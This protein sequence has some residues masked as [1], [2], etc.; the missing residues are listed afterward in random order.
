[1]RRGHRGDHNV[2][3][4]RLRTLLDWRG[5]K[6]EASVSQFLTPNVEVVEHPDGHVLI[7]G[8]LAVSHVSAAAVTPVAAAQTALVVADL[9]YSCSLT[10]FVG[11]DDAG[12]VL[13]Q[14]LQRT[15]ISLD[16]LMVAQ[17]PTYVA[18]PETAV[19]PEEAAGDTPEQQRVLPFNGMSE[20]QAHL[21]NRVE[22]GVRN[23][24]RLLVIDQGY[25]SV[26]DPRATVFA[27][28]Q[29]DIPCLVFCAP[30]QAKHYAKASSIVVEVGATADAAAIEQLAQWLRASQRASN[31]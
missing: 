16:V 28:T 1:M 17:W 19:M 2:S 29:C 8:D 23:A 14:T 31:G 13:Q 24:S 26:G 25:G 30:H 4:Q 20:Y 18:T 11:D 21:Q 15:A 6:L 22:R 7:V 3:A 10:G 27:A 12:A 9:G 5:R